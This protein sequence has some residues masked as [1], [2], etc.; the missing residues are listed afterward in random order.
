MT[1]RFFTRNQATEEKG[2]TLKGNTSNLTSG[3]NPFFLGSTNYFLLEQIPND[4]GCENIDRIAS[5]T[6]VFFSLNSST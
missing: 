6:S 4:K 5:L 2:S 3:A 1:S